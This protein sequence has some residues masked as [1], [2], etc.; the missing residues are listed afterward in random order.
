MTETISSILERSWETYKKH[1]KLLIPATVITI[2]LAVL[3]QTVQKIETRPIIAII[4]TIIA[5]LITIGITLGWAQMVLRLLRTKKSSWKDF[6]TSLRIWKHFVVAQI[7]Y[8]VFKIPVLIL[9]SPLLGYIVAM[10]YDGRAIFSDRGF[11][12][13]AL[14]FAIGVIFMVWLSIRYMFL[15]FVAV[16]HAGMTGWALLKKSAAMTK[17]NEWQLL[18][19]SIT[20]ALINIIGLICL[21]VGLLVSIPL[22][23][24]AKADLYESLKEKSA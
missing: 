14:M 6:K 15:S 16:D 22:T 4:V 12:A 13:V 18:K 24:L 10:M 9:C 1:W 8:N 7:I 19:F 20:L 17:N 2:V 3:N 21:V 5:I 11:M 23:K